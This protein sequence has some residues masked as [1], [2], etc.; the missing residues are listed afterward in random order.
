MKRDYQIVGF[1]QGE[2]WFEWCP[3]QS[4]AW[5]RR[6]QQK[7]ASSYSSSTDNSLGLIESFRGNVGES[8]S[9]FKLQV[10]AVEEK[11]GLFYKNKCESHLLGEAEFSQ[12]G[13][14]VGI[15]EDVNGRIA[16]AE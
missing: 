8:P 3:F 2:Q 13:D 15:D 4:H 9:R 1:H 5:I 12:F 11:S 6:A 7:D 16:P 14:N 10:R